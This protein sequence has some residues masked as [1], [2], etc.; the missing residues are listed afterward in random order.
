MFPFYFMYEVIPY[1]VFMD[2]LFCVLPMYSQI[3]F[4]CVG[5]FASVLS[6]FFS[7]MLIVLLCLFLSFFAIE[8]AMAKVHEGRKEGDVR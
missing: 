4:F 2:K 8:I 3:C 1:A 5:C 6:Y 7:S